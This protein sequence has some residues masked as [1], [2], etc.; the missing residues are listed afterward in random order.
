MQEI[1]QQFIDQIEQDQKLSEN[2]KYAYKSDLN[3]LLEYTIST[4]T[5]PQNINHIWVKNYL[6]H[7]E[8]TNKERNSY[9]RRASTFR[10]FLRFLYRH[11]LA[12]TNYS[13]IVSNLSIFSKITDDNLQTEDIKKIIEDTKLKD[14]QRLILLLI[15]KLGL[16]AT[17]I[18]SIKTF[19]IDFE[20]KLINLSDTEKI[21]L[22]PEI[23]SVL[24]KYI[25]EIRAALDSGSSSLSLFL[26]EAGAPLA[27]TDIYKL[28]KKLSTDLK[29]EGKLTTRNL[30]NSLEN[31]AD[32]WTIQ[33][34]IF[35][36]I[37]RDRSSS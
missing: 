34:E 10:I 36:V 22:P 24:R 16:T 7:L 26:N 31:K 27:E 14:D 11:K 28:I 35:N 2:T 23:F 20:N 5:K 17:Q 4:D 19:Q 15:G 33:K 21:Y 37:A 18:A 12:P 29:L 32:I 8:E 13:L 25:L 30:K 1:I 6:K 3:D 9:N